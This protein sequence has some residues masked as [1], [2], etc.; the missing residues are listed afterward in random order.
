M[1]ISRTKSQHFVLI[2]H[3]NFLVA[4]SEITTTGRFPITDIGNKIPIPYPCR[5][6]LIRF[7]AGWE[8]QIKIKFIMGIVNQL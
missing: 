8:S 6:T 1:L 4:R 5:Y 3:P 2:N 7:C